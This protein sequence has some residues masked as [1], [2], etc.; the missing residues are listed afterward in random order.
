MG[1][2]VS[3]GSSARTDQ[4]R[5]LSGSAVCRE[6]TVCKTPG[7]AAHQPPREEHIVMQRFIKAIVLS[8]AVALVCAPA[9]ARADGYVNPWAGVNFGTP[10]NCCAL[11]ITAPTP[12]ALK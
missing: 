6:H 3:S 10:G 2:A 11:S 12:V 4:I 7:L 8:A 5:L 9:T 1:S